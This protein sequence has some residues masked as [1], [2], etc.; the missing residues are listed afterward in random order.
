MAQNPDVV[1]MD[2]VRDV[3]GLEPLPEGAGR[4][5]R[6]DMRRDYREPEPVEIETRS[7]A[8]PVQKMARKADEDDIEEIAEGIP[9]EVFVAA[10]IPEMAG[11]GAQFA[12]DALREVGTQVSL[13][14]FDDRIRALIEERAL[15]QSRVIVESRRRELRETLSEG[16]AAGET[17]PA[18]VSRI[19]AQLGG[20]ARAFKALRIARTEIVW[21]SNNARQEAHVA[22]GVRIREWLATPDEVTR[23]DHWNLD[24]VRVAIDQPFR[25]G[26]DT[27]MF[28]GGFSRPANSI[29]C[30]CT[31]LPVIDGVSTRMLRADAWK[32]LDN[33][34]HEFE[35]RLQTAVEGVFIELERQAMARLEA[36]Q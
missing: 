7:T 35:R 9:E 10:L 21:S 23:P 28:P 5:L 18:L 25:I 26:D 20:D 17:T 22:A 11:A 12:E 15:E 29:N 6:A 3:L 16:V 2:E 36:I 14:L 30:R 8:A 33:E 19:R 32:V 24:G 34:R 31:T 1:L 27:A 4:R 13:D